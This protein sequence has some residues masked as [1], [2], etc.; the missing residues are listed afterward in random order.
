MSGRGGRLGATRAS[1]VRSA[2]IMVTSD[3]KFAEIATLTASPIPVCVDH[4]HGQGREGLERFDG[5]RQLD[6]SIAAVSPHPAV[7]VS[8]L[9]GHISLVMTNSVEFHWVLDD[10]FARAL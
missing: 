2:S 5:K 8:I 10:L 7:N 4:L 9:R 6:R 1:E 3:A